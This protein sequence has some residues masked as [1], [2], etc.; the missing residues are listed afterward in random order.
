[1]P[2]R[3]ESPEIELSSVRVMMTPS[4]TVY[5]ADSAYFASLSAFL[6]TWLATTSNR[7]ETRLAN[8]ASN[9]AST[10]SGRAP[11]LPATAVITSMS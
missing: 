1:M 6:V 10:N 7:L 9:G 2:W 4:E 3:S 5:G 8:N 11:N